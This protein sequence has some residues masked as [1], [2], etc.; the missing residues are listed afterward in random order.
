M[1]VIFFKSHSD[2]HTFS[3]CAERKSPIVLKTLGKVHLLFQKLC[4]GIACVYSVV[5]RFKLLF[6][7]HKSSEYR[8]RFVV[9][10]YFAVSENMLLHKPDG[11]PRLLHNRALVIL[12]LYARKHTEKSGFSS[13][14]YPRK[15][16]FI[17][18]VHRK[19]DV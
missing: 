10:A 11:K 2:K 3:S 8:K 19:V 15:A 6:R 1:K 18:F 13:S 16:Y 14:V 7:L 5:E 4:V 9:N 12:R 17:V